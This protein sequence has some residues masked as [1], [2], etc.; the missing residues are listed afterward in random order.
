M[1]RYR[2]ILVDEF[3]FYVRISTSFLRSAQGISSIRKSLDLLYRAY[4]EYEKLLGFGRKDKEFKK[5][6]KKHSAKLLKE[7]AKEYDKAIA[8]LGIKPEDI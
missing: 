8:R 4:L 2:Q 6:L 3:T 7:H 1:N 5:E